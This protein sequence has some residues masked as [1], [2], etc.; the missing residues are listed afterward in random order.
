MPPGKFCAWYHLFPKLQLSMSTDG[1]VLAAA[2][3]AA[4]LQN[5]PNTIVNVYSL[6]A[7][8]LANT[9]P[10]SSG[11]PV[12]ISVSG[13]G[14]VIGMY[15]ASTSGCAAETIP[16]AGGR[17]Y[18]AGM[19]A[20]G[21][22]FRLTE[23]WSPRC[24][25]L[26]LIRHRSWFPADTPAAKPAARHQR[27][28]LFVEHQ[29]DHVTDDGCTLWASADTTCLFACNCLGVGAIT[30]SQVIFTSGASVLAQPY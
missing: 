1:K 21:F 14:S 2:A 26:Q 8:T 29:Y 28:D 6:P 10:L 24:E 30:G 23:L 5:P 18:G 3:V 22:R 20:A 9:F 13:N 19:Q 17:H 11:F 15:P 12:Q 16:V 7:A 4:P 27:F 25:Y